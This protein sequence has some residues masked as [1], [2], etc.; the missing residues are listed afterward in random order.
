LENKRSG[1]EVMK[2]LANVINKGQSEYEG[3]LAERLGSTHRGTL[4]ED[5]DP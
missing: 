1:D 3:S 4:G 5:V 2:L